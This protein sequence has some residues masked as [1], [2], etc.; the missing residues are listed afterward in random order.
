MVIV[1]IS[2]VQEM[3]L[4][5][6]ISICILTLFNNADICALFFSLTKVSFL[7]TFCHKSIFL[8]CPRH[9]MENMNL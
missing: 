6:S 8:C 5:N 4:P 1:I 7:T 3:Q 9:F 2:A